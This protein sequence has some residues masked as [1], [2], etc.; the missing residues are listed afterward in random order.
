MGRPKTPSRRRF[1]RWCGQTTFCSSPDEPATPH[2]D[3]TGYIETI[4]KRGYR[5]KIR[6]A[7]ADA[8]AGCNANAYSHLEVSGRFDMASHLLAAALRSLPVS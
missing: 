6:R 8:H 1:E 4:P 3:S 2:Q 7:R 5:L